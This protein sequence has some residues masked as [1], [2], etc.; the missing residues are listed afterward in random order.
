MR[1][2]VG[3]GEALRARR[4]ILGFTLEQLAK[5]SGVSRAMLSDVERGRKSP[6]LRV[7]TQIAAALG[8]M[9]SELLAGS[10]AA[11]AE[12]LRATE[13]S[14]LIDPESGVSRTV[15]SRLLLGRGLEMIWYRFPPLA[16]TGTFPAHGS[17]T[18][19]HITVLTGSIEISLPTE[20][21]TL[22]AG[23]SATFNADCRHSLRNLSRR[24]S[25]VMLLIA[26]SGAAS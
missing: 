7:A 12:I 11:S 14:G 2:P 15:L 23:D 17:G 13:R 9:L 3:F 19:E 16:A 21:I 1:K 6:T 26:H 24:Q 5:R 18:T 20:I 22:R 10:V 25:E 4:G 8:V